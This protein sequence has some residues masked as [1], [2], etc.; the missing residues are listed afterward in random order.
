MKVNGDE[1][2]DEEADGGGEVNSDEE[3][4]E[5]VEEVDEEVYVDAMHRDAQQGTSQSVPER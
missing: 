2:V 4:D 3:V 5:E 1:E